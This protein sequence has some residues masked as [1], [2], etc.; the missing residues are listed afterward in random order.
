MGGLKKEKGLVGP[1]LDTHDD[2]RMGVAL[3]MAIESKPRDL[4]L[5]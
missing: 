2:R 5:A 3:Y 4:F 1:H